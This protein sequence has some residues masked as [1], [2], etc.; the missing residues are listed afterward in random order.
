MK[1]FLG[2]GKQKINLACVS[3][4]VTMAHLKGVGMSGHRIT[5]ALEIV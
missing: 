2:I 5:I 4:I 1:F 3:I